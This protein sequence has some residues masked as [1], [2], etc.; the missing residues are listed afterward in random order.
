MSKLRRLS[1]VFAS[2]ACVLALGA[3]ASAA[4]T[5]I[6]IS[7]ASTPAAPRIQPPLVVGATPST[8]FLF[9]IPAT[10]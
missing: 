8:P 3:E 7:M 1:L 5:T 4:Q 10:G 6:T 2:L 9:A